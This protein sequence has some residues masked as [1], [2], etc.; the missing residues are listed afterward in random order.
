MNPLSNWGR[1]VVDGLLTHP[2][3]FAVLE[4]WAPAGPNAAG[5]KKEEPKNGFSAVPSPSDR[6]GGV[7]GPFWPSLGGTQ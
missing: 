3:F 6:S 5:A 4:P 2:P 7:C 1:W